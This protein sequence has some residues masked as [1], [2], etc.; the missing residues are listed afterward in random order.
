MG[1]EL[2][3]VDLVMGI[4]ERKRP[5]IERIMQLKRTNL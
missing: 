4:V 1:V 3:A 2:F 5:K